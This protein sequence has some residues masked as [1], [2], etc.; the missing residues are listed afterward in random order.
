MEMK[1]KMLE[2]CPAPKGKEFRRQWQKPNTIRWL[3]KLSQ[4]QSYVK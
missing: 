2:G 3:E 4:G 1:R